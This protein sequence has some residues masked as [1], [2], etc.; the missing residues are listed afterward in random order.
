MNEH[1]QACLQE[2]GNSVGALRDESARLLYLDLAN[3]W[4]NM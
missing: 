2:G 3:H 4:L 1:A